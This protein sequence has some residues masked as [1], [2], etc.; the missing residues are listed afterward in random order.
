VALP[1]QLLPLVSE[2]S[3]LQETVTRLLGLPQLAPVTIVCNDNH[4][5]MVSDQLSAM[6]ISTP[7]I[8]L[9]PAGRNT[10]PAVA[11][12]AILS[13]QTNPEGILL[14]LPADHLIQDAQVFHQAVQQAEKLAE[15]GYLVTFGIVPGGAETCYG[16][17]ERGSA[18]EGCSEAFRVS[19]FVE[20]PDL[21]SA[22]QFINSGSFFW[23]SGMFVF[24]ADRYLEELQRYR[25]DI[26][27]A[28][29]IAVD[30]GFQDLEF[31]RLDAEAFLSCPSDSIDY[32]VMEKTDGAVVLAVNI[33]WND[34]GNWSSLWDVGEKDEVGNVLQGDVLVQECTDCLIRSEHRL[35]TAI[36]IRDAIIIETSDAVM[37]LDK[38]S[39][40]Q[41]KG[42]VD[43]LK[44]QQRPEHN[45]HRR[46]YRPW[47]YY[48]NIDEGYRFLVKRMMVKPGAK[49][50]LQM[51]HH[52]AEH[53]VVVSGTA[54]VT[55]GEE[56]LL[57]GENQ[58]TY[59]SMGVVHR[60]ENPGKIPLQMIEVQ[61]GAYLDEDDIVRI[62]DMY[63]R[64]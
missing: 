59:I 57:L 50:S 22:Q 49:L 64:N 38:G 11:V 35:V 24:R 45:G 62:E 34:I 36:G 53:W 37:V 17:I 31:W 15:Q 10:A 39:A 52:R 33:G 30:G 58:S 55:R 48:E 46:V 13:L 12:A 54:L 6:P 42:L 1:K 20:K 27:A 23:N 47:G 28:C 29:Q 51:H 63:C 7:Q 3:L 8:I 9:E 26:L 21:A 60:L 32:A 61:S 2:K 14:V 16:Y 43:S 4:R 56:S 41:V 44:A 19:S 25:P 40:Q 18:I 5:F